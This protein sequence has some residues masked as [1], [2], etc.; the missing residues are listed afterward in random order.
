M[1]NVIV[2]NDEKQQTCIALY[3]SRYIFT[4]H[5]FGAFPSEIGDMNMRHL[6][7]VQK[8][9]KIQRKQCIHLAVNS[10]S[11]LIVFVT[12]SLHVFCP[13]S[14]FSVFFFVLLSALAFADEICQAYNFACHIFGF[15]LGLRGP[16]NKP[17]GAGHCGANEGVLDTSIVLEY[18]TPWPDHVMAVRSSS[19]STW[20]STTDSVM[21]SCAA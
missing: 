11:T 13:H 12:C 19:A 7:Q 2:I 5:W 4:E 20:L 1:Q 8:T 3:I 16:D 9:S 21:P 18:R 14:L 17:E 15:Y 10:W 6:K